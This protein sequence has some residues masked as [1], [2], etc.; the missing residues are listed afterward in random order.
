MWWFIIAAIGW[1]LI[2]SCVTTECRKVCPPR[3]NGGCEEQ[4]RDRGEW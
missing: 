1:F 4:C 3:L 2:V